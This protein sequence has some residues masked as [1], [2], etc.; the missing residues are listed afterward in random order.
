MMQGISVLASSGR[1]HHITPVATSAS[2]AKPE[3]E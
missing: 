1:E 2:S 3:E